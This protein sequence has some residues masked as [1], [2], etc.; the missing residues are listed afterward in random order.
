MRVQLSIAC[1]MAAATALELFQGTDKAVATQLAQIS[2]ACFPNV[3]CGCGCGSDEGDG[4]GEGVE[5]T[6]DGHMETEVDVVEAAVD[7]I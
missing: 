2:A 6:P 3:E 7:G 5:E 4:P 1:L